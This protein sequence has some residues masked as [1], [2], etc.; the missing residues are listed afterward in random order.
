[1]STSF[2]N[3]PAFKISAGLGALLLT[4]TGIAY[5]QYLKEQEAIKNGSLGVQ[6]VGGMNRLVFEAFIE[7]LKQELAQELKTKRVSLPVFLSINQACCLGAVDTNN[8]LVKLDRELRRGLNAIGSEAYYALLQRQLEAENNNWQQKFDD[9]LTSLGIDF[10][11]FA[12]LYSQFVS[13]NPRVKDELLKMTRQARKNL[14]T[15]N[16]P[17]TLTVE[18]ALRILTFMIEKYDSVDV[19]EHFKVNDK[20]QVKR[21]VIFDLIHQEFNGFEEEWFEKI[22]GL[23][24]NQEFLDLNKNFALK[25]QQYALSIIGGGLQMQPAPQQEESQQLEEEVQKE[26]DD[27]LQVVNEEEEKS[28]VEVEAEANEEEEEGANEEANIELNE[29]ESPETEVESETV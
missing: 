23:M 21:V 4:G 15:E 11:F 22:E 14:T 9:T 10:N 18:L 27:K 12:Q 25:A 26:E 24:E 17:D 3:S 16:L 8:E 28:E 5:I 19:P 20:I 7:N 1:M 13:Q 6:T 2:F 29:E